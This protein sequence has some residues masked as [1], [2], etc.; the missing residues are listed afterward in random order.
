MNETLPPNGEHAAFIKAKT[1]E[2]IAYVKN[3]RSGSYDAQRFTALA[4]NDYERAAEWAV[5]ALS[6]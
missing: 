5:K 4:I 3:N 2:L 1:D 6:S